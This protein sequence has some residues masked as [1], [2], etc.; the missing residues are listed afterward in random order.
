ME[1]ECQKF[2]FLLKKYKNLVFLRN[3]RIT[4]FPKKSFKKIISNLVLLEFER[5]INA[6]LFLFL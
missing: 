6:K 3:L 5:K 1:I 4:M 2:N